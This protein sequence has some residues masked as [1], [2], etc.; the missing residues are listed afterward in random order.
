MYDTLQHIT[1][2]K[3]AL[4]ECIRVLKTAG[5][6][7]IIEYNKQG[8]EYYQKTEGFTID[9]VDPRDLLDREAISTEV[10]AGELVNMYILRK[11]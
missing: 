11:T 6:I 4:T 7:G 5:I 10:I 3:T 2:R 9:Y 8:I 1:N